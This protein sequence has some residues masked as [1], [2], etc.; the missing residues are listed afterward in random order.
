MVIA[1]DL[2]S[3][4]YHLTGIER[5]AA[6]VSD[7]MLERDECNFYVLIFRNEIYPLFKNK[8][9][10]KRVIA[11]IIRGDNKFIFYQLILPYHLYKLKADCY[12]FLAF[13]SPILFRKKGIYN[14]IHDMGAWDASESMKK[15]QKIYWRV[16]MRIAVK[17]SKGIITVSEFSKRR[18]IELLKCPKEKIH[19]I[20]SAVYEG[21]TKDYCVDFKTIREKYHLPDKY[22]MMLSTLEPRK[23]MSILLEVFSKIADDVDYDLV[24]VGRK[25]WMMDQV[26]GRYNKQKR[27]H[28]TGYVKDE[29]VSHIYKNA[30]CFVFPSLYEGFGLPPVEALALGTPVI[31]SDAA[32]IPEIL[33]KQ[34]VYFKSNSMSELKNI[35][36]GLEEE[37][38]VMP[39]ELNEYQKIEY[40]FGRSAEKVLKLIEEDNGDQE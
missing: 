37:L 32:S 23:N 2:T 40:D 36:L 22:I 13:N 27:I 34:A 6:C 26:L 4:S 39:H 30:L 19:V 12:L 25:G 10:G 7:K 5:Y 24:L 35:L 16:T 15:S 38:N 29:H 21:I 28:I 11:K 3:L 18:I 17:L 8:I 14:A 20:Y 31:A 33:Q 1:I 9:D